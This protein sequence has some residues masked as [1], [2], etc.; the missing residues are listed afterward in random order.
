MMDGGEPSKP[1]ADEERSL[2]G[3]SAPQWSLAANLI[4]VFSLGFVIIGAAFAW[5]E[6]RGSQERFRAEQTLAMIDQW[7]SGNYRAA[8]I[9]LRETTRDFYN[10]V[11]TAQVALAASDRDAQT[12]LD[13]HLYRQAFGDQLNATAVS[14]V[15]YFFN[16][17][18]LCVST[19]I[20][21]FDVARAFFDDTLS[22]F[23]NC[24]RS[25]LE[26]QEQGGSHSKGQSAI[27]V[28]E[29][30]FAIPKRNCAAMF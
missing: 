8:Y 21:S 15:V 27:L 29:Q 25:Y 30:R 28:L 22:T 11:P 10:T 5:M 4:T 3:L 9:R 2:L 1:P 6:Y 19:D 13:K 12:A 18:A 16:R 20:C 7:E 17:L 24:Y 26:L 14:D 23:L